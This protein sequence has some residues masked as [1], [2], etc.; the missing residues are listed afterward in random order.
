MDALIGTPLNPAT[1]D[2][3]G[4]VLFNAHAGALWAR[5]TTYL[6]REIVARLGMTHAHIG[7]TATLYAHVRLRLQRDA[8]DT[9]STA[10][11]S[12]GITDT[13]SSD[14]D[15]QPPCAALVR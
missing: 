8:I 15:E 3:A 10:L 12:G 4:A 9:L 6:R 14:G 2:Y 11:S 13:A 1:Y 5:F 7:V